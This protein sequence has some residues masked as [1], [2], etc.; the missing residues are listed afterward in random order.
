MTVR[1]GNGNLALNAHV[2]LGWGACVLGGSTVGEGTV[3][4]MGTILKGRVPN[5][6][7][8][9]GAPA[10]VIRKDIAWERPH[11]SLVEPYYKPDASTIRKSR[12]WKLTQSADAAKPPRPR[13]LAARAL[14]RLRRKVRRVL[15]R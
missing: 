9:A 1:A 3:L 5:N 4:G 11:L 12:Y 10:R 15:T 7:V 13:S 2:W 8:A 6:V 14:S